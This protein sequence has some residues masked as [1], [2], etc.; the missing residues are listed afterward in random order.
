M[1]PTARKYNCSAPKPA[2][3]EPIDPSAA[4]FGILSDRVIIDYLQAIMA[5]PQAL[6]AG[7]RMIMNL[8]H[9]LIP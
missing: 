1:H 6:I 2:P 5:S 4:P 8:P 9:P 7:C 3:R